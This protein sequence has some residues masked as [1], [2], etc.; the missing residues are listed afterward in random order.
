MII[1][2]IAPE[3]AT[4]FEIAEQAAAAN[5]H[6]V[7]RKGRIALCG[8][9]NIPEGWHRMSVGARLTKPAQVPA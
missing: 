6:I 5:V 1:D 7:E 8:A 9:A 4:L 2:V 3:D